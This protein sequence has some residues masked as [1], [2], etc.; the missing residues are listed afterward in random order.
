MTKDVDREL[1][2]ESRMTRVEIVSW[3]TGAGVAYLMFGATIIG[4]VAATMPH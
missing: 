2:M 1:R 4:A 3:L